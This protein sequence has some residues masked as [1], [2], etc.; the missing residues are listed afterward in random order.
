MDKTDLTEVTS[1]TLNG[2]IAQVE[3]PA[4]SGFLTLCANDW[5][6]KDV[7]IGWQRRRLRGLPLCCDGAPVCACLCPSTKPWGDT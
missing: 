2:D 6:A 3:T 5:T 1:F 4:G 7:K